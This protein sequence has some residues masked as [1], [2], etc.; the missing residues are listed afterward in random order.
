MNSICSEIHTKQINVLCGQKF[1][2]LRSKS[3]GKFLIHW[4]VNGSAVTLTKCNIV[5]LSNTVKE[6]PTKG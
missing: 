5:Y 1:E 3:G 2:F 6:M 4:A